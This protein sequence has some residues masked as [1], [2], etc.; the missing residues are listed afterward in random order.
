MPLI[1]RSAHVDGAIF[2]NED[3][4]LNYDKDKKANLL[5]LN[6]ENNKYPNGVKEYIKLGEDQEVNKGY[7]CSIRD[8]WY[9]VP[10]V[11]IPDA[12]FLRRNNIFPKFVMNN[13][14]A[15]STDTMH[16]IKFNDGIDGENVLLSYYNSISFA[17]TEI[18]GRSY[19]GGVLE[20]LPSEV[21][22]IMLPIINGIPEEIKNTMLSYIDLNL[23]NSTDIETILDEVDRVVLVEY[24]G[25]QEETCT[26]F[27]QI[28]RK[29]N[30][31]RLGRAR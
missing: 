16:R 24:L 18:N 23:R 29:L 14:Q 4:L 21:G 26:R 13:I 5:V 22:S 10:S 20:I 17:F 12:F 31:R 3:Y 9:E 8:N 27:R 28:W 25:I 1:G 11:W 2:T 30:N 19:G 7:K 6:K 15:V